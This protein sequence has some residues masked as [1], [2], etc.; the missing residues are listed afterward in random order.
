MRIALYSKQL[1][2]LKR[3]IEQLAT[4]KRVSHVR[5]AAV[6]TATTEELSLHNVDVLI[7]DDLIG[8]WITPAELEKLGNAHPDVLIMLITRQDSSALFVD[9]VGAGVRSILRWPAT[10]AEI[11][12]AIA[13]CLD[14]LS[15]HGARHEGRTFTILAAKGGSG[16]TFIAL[17]LAYV[18]ATRLDKR[19][20]I[21]DL[22]LQYGDATFGLGESKH[23]SNVVQVAQDETLEASYLESA[24]VPLRRNLFLLPSPVSLEEAGRLEPARLENLLVLASRLFDVVIID[25]PIHIDRLATACM[26]HSNQVLQVV[27]PTVVDLRNQQRQLR[28][29]HDLGIPI[30]KVGTLINRMPTA[31]RRRRNVDPF[32]TE[33]E[34]HLSGRTLATLPRDDD[35]ASLSIGAGESV[36][37]VAPDSPL[38]RA[39]EAAASSLLGVAAAQQGDRSPWSRWLSLL[40]R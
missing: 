26:E 17:N 3:L 15:R 7:L 37:T 30:A 12:H 23:R 8:E 22:D 1:D 2:G 35:A 21:I 33:I 6:T 39:I 5:T 11:D 29:L 32:A 38:S 13:Q 9:A 19:T 16:A 14:R 20:L 28:Y 40:R 36:V 31:E 27:A 34:R 25:V 24:C 18:W 10:P 4:D